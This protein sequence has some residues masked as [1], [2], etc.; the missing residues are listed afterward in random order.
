[1][2]QMFSDMSE[3]GLGLHYRNIA[4]RQDGTTSFQLLRSDKPVHVLM[5][6]NNQPLTKGESR[7]YIS[8]SVY[9]GKY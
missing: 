2:I 8:Y 3:D 7:E 1:M 9:L 4:K 6:F 5:F